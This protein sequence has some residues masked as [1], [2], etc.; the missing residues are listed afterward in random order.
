MALAAAA[1]HVEPGANRQDTVVKSK[2][3]VILVVAKG[4]ARPDNKKL[5][6]PSELKARMLSSDEVV[7][8]TGHP[9][10]GVCP[11]GLGKP[12]GDIL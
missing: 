7:T 11:F 3:E 2:N 9:I 6:V 12:R 8:I 1:H 5:K 4:N 10:G